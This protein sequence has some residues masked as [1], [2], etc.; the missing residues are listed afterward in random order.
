MLTSKRQRD[1]S[2]GARQEVDGA[3]A[4]AGS[5]LPDLP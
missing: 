2:V 5:R 3:Q 1:L 4:T